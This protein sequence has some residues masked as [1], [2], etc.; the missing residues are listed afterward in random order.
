MCGVLSCSGSCPPKF[1][2]AME[3]EHCS[4]VGFDFEFQQK[5]KRTHPKKEWDIVMKNR[6]CPIEELKGNRRIP[7]IDELLKLPLANK[8]TLQKS[9][10]IAIVLYSG[11]M[12]S[13][14]IYEIVP[15]I[16]FCSHNL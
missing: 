11:P 5:K 15:S 16:I 12:V 4:K 8:A 10:L 1:F 2:E 6:Q 13:F 3:A 9:E 7:D 14:M